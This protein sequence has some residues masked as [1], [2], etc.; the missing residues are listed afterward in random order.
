MIIKK[1]QRKKHENAPTCIVYEYGHRD[2]NINVAFA[3]INGRYPENGFSFNEVCKEIFFVL[4]GKGKIE[5][6]GKEMKLE[7]GDAVLIQPQQ[8]YFLEG[9]LK[10]VIS[11]NPAWN[12]NQYK[13]ID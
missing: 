4:E 7:Q 11:C 5:I 13:V 9:K 3:E 10:L 12:P 6:N 1:S 8:K 2:N